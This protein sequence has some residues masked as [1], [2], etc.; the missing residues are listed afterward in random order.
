MFGF[1]ARKRYNAKVDTIL[2]NDFQIVTNSIANPNFPGILKYMELIDNVYEGKVPESN[3]FGISFR[4][5]SITGSA[6]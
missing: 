1:G 4:K 6:F 2:T 5:V 3:C